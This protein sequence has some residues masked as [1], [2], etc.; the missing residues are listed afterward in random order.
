ML[1][2]LAPFSVGFNWLKEGPGIEI[3]YG[4]DGV[5]K[6]DDEMIIDFHPG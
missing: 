3:I 1:L 5:M 4:T 2:R 6:V